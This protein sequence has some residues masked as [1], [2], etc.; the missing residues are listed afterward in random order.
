MPINLEQYNDNGKR[1]G[2]WER[3]HVNNQLFFKGK[4]VDGEQHGYWEFYYFD[5]TLA[6]KGTYDLGKRIGYWAEGISKL[7]YAD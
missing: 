2:L 5:G 7:F 3:Y 4:Y 1:H 6:Y